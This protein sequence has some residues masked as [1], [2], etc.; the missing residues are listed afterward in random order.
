[1]SR[2][3]PQPGLL[4][5]RHILRS[6][7]ELD[8]NELGAIF[9]SLINLVLDDAAYE[10]ELSAKAA[11]LHDMAIEAVREN[12]EAYCQKANFRGAVGA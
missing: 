11:V 4:L 3:I 7:R 2:G 1:M 10:L 9:A 12:A 6:L 8:D 5:P